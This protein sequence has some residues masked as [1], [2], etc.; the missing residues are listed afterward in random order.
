MEKIIVINDD[1]KESMHAAEYAF[2]LAC[3]YHKHIILAN[4][5]SAERSILNQVA[6]SKAVPAGFELI[7][8][9]EESQET[10]SDHLN[11]LKTE[12]GFHP[13]IKTLDAS[14][15]GEREMIAYVNSHR[16]W[17]IVRGLAAESEIRSDGMRINM[18]SLLNRI[19]CPIMLVPEIAPVKKIER[20]VYLADLRYAQIPVINYLAK[21]RIE[22]QSV[23]IAH[24]RVKGLP[25]LEK[26][27]AND[28]FSKVLA[29]QVACKNLFFSH[30]HANR[31]SDAIDTVIHGMEGNM[32]VCE[33]HSYHFKQILGSMV[34]TKVPGYISVPVLV[35]PY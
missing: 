35:F 17:M 9:D 3:L 22:N 23:I 33:N 21:W 5:V 32:L 11:C 20:M 7:L 29:R 34:T 13:E 30:L 18:Q 12:S 8:G 26:S 16:V 4:L 27:Y 28:L 14:K 15:F 24:I 10:V 19:L 6:R 25:E 2:H 31:F 1:S